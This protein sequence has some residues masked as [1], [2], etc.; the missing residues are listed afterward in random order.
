MFIY[1]IKNN[2][3]IVYS[4]VDTDTHMHMHVVSYCAQNT[5]DQSGRRKTRKTAPSFSFFVTCTV[6]PPLHRE[7][8]NKEEAQAKNE[9]NEKFM[10]KV[11][12]QKVFSSIYNIHFYCSS[13]LCKPSSIFI[14]R[15]ACSR[16]CHATTSTGSRFLVIHEQ[17]LLVT[18][19][20]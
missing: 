20:I 18:F 13:L 4:E 14:T 2:V 1:A 9:A 16:S 5:L 11:R 6:R 15:V 10:R 3:P 12:R 7:M 19:P 17:C 8:Q